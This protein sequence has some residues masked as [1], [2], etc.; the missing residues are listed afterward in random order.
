MIINHVSVNCFQTSALV[1]EII[2]VTQLTVEK[3]A[4][5]VSQPL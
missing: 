3:C 5:V 4:I 2:D 1:A